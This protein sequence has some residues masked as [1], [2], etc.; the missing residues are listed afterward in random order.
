MSRGPTALEHRI[1]DGDT[2]SKLAER[3]LG[4]G[5]RYLEIYDL[6]R[7]V[8][9]SPDLLPIGVVLKIPPRVVEPSAGMRSQRPGQELPLEPPADMVPVERQSASVQSSG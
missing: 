7:E 5:D 4:R 8:L 9:A 3:Y 2:L 6:N 1:A